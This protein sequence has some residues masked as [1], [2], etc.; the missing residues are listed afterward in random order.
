[1]QNGYTPYIPRNNSV[2][3]LHTYS[4]LGW[5]WYMRCNHIFVGGVCRHKYN[6]RFYSTNCTRG[7]CIYA[8]VGVFE[9]DD[10]IGIGNGIA[11]AIA[12]AI[13]IGLELGLY[14]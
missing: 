10:W 8:L 7:D 12:I 11:I 14:Q 1:M 2:D 4:R 3:V 5:G 9:V 13:A 6:I